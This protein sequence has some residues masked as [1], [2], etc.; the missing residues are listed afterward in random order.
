MNARQE[1]ERVLN[2]LERGIVCAT[3]QRLGDT[4]FSVN[5]LEEK[6]GSINLRDI[7]TKAEYEE[8]M[9]KLD[10][11]YDAGYG[12]QVLDGIVWL[13]NGSWL[14][15]GEY[16]GSEWWAHRETPKVPEWLKTIKK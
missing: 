16:D 11:E 10:F 9:Q 14:E 6:E 2:F 12:W 1:L 13:D 3:I 5:C 7:H 8:F 15:R 4:D